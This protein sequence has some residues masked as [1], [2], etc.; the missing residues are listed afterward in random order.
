MN[1]V[2]IRTYPIVNKRFDEE[3]QKIVELLEYMDRAGK[4]PSEIK[5]FPADYGALVGAITYGG[6]PLSSH[7][8]SRPR[9]GSK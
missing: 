4:R 5:L 2:D 6:I 3:R 9:A 8:Y 7:A 1:V